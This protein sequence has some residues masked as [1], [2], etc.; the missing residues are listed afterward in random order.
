MTAYIV[1]TREHVRDRAEL[2]RYSAAVGAT[3]AGHAA[4]PLAAY[5]PIERLEGATPEER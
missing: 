3:F 5:G 4:T 2:D 1:F